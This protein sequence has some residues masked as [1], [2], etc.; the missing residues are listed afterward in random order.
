MKKIKIVIIICLVLCLIIIASI[1][2]IRKGNDIMQDNLGDPGEDINYETAEL[3]DIDDRIQYYTVINCI[4]TYLNQVK[5]DNLKYYDKNDQGEYVLIA[6]QE[7]INEDIYQLLSQEYIE[8]NGITI[9]NVLEY[10]DNIEDN[11]YYVPLKMKVLEASNTYKYVVFGFIQTS[12]NEFLKDANYIVNLDRNNKTF[13]IELLT[14]EYNSTEDVNINNNNQNIEANDNNNYK[15]AVVNN[16]YVASDYFNR[17]KR[18]SL[19]NSEI[20]YEYLND[21]YKNKRFESLEEY[22]SYVETNKDELSK[23]RIDQYLINN[24][25][26]YTEYVCKDQYGNLY[27]FDEQDI[28]NFDIKLDTY[29]IDTEKFIE[30]Y[31]SS[32]DE[33]KVKLNID[34]WVKM[35]NNRDYKNAFNYLDETFRTNNFN[36]DATTFENYMR[37]QYPAH[38]EALYGDITERSG[39]FGQN[40]VFRNIDDENSSEQTLDIIMSLQEDM[41]FV[42]SFTIYSK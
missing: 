8:K 34:K 32:S 13:S 41:N 39:V 4:E 25:D 7:E 3:K 21:E 29:T 38:Y 36:N 10:V 15:D 12:Q 1:F 24:Y 5:K 22:I 2:A 27:I 20:A 17:Y 35:I 9:E 30:Q 23:I 26:G 16:E 6:S 28:N 19:T 33:N 18:M 40:I 11:Y 42:M 14:D 37:R 31:N